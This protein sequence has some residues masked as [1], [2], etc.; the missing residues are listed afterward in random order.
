MLLRPFA[1]VWADTETYWAG[2][3]P[4]QVERA[5]TDGRHKMAL[6]FRWYLGMSSRWARMGEAAR[7]KDFQIWCGPAMGSFND[8]VAGSHLEDLD[9]RRVVD[10]AHALLSGAAGLRRVT[11]ARTL[12]A[13]KVLLPPG[14][15]DVRPSKG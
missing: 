9:N 4:K 14:L 8:W 3:D 2:R 7:K 10:V 13:G 15:E 11:L 1:E 12:L 5:R 6:V